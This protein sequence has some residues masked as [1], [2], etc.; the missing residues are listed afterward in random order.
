M[1]SYWLLTKNVVTHTHTII[2]N[3]FFNLLKEASNI[4]GVEL[5]NKAIISSFSQ[6]ALVTKL[7]GYEFT[8]YVKYSDEWK[9][10]AIRGLNVKNGKLKLDDIKYIDNI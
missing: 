7:A 10:I 4:V 3:N 8:K 5:Y 1:R 2:P 6:F 9:I